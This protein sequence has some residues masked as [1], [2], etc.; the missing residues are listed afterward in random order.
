[1]T[2]IGSTVQ[3][4]GRDIAKVVDVLLLS[5]IIDSMKW[6]IKNFVWEQWQ[7]QREYSPQL[8]AAIQALREL[9]DLTG[10][11]IRFCPCCDCPVEMG[12]ADCPVCNE[13]IAEHYS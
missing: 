10:R 1:M 5:R 7:S 8:K 11:V 3:N 2:Q 4:A 13:G 9:S 12:T 6:M